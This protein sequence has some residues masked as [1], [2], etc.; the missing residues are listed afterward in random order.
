MALQ[1]EDLL[2]SDGHNTISVKF[3]T[4]LKIPGV[5]F[6]NLRQLLKTVGGTAG[7]LEAA[8]RTC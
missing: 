6:F 1:L 8:I 5:C 2:A 7:D 3:A 4:G